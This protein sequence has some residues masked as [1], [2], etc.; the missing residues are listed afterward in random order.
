MVFSS[1]LKIFDG[2][3]RKNFRIILYNI[4]YIEI[5]ISIINIKIILK[6]WSISWILICLNKSALSF[7]QYIFKNEIH[8]RYQNKISRKMLFLKMFD[9][10]NLLD[11]WICRYRRKTLTQFHYFYLKFFQ[12]QYCRKCQYRQTFTWSD[13]P[14]WI[15]LFGP[16]YRNTT[17]IEAG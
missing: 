15:H 8:F 3:K 14:W 7:H 5:N 4:T 10:V 16:A 11:C 2:R 6:R 12:C 1:G 13:R 17:L 9:F